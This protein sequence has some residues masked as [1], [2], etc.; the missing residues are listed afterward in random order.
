MYAALRSARASEM[1]RVGWRVIRTLG[2][3]SQAADLKCIGPNKAVHHNRIASVL[4]VL[5]YVIRNTP[6]TARSAAVGYVTAL[7]AA[8]QNVYSMKALF[9]ADLVRPRDS[10]AQPRRMNRIIV[11]DTVARRAHT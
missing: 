10:L 8:P 5:A 7:A 3:L 6:G 2:A 11:C 9:K 4:Q 1:P